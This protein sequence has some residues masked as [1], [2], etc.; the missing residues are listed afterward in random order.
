MAEHDVCETTLQ[1][2]VSLR[3]HLLAQYITAK[4][5]NN[6]AGKK[7]SCTV[8]GRRKPTKKRTIGNWLRPFYV[9]N[10]SL[11]N[12]YV[13]VS[14]R[15]YVCACACSLRAQN[16]F[17]WMCACVKDSSSKNII[18]NTLSVATHT[19]TAHV[20]WA[21]DDTI[22]MSER[23]VDSLALHQK[24]GNDAL[25]RSRSRNSSCGRSL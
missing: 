12:V 15:A 24:F 17:V 5:V 14:A 13:C 8:K 22:H 11:V 1:M 7:V 18:A 2:F 4:I 3:I 19:R 20:L 23:R 16:I 25:L 6:G 10:R 9:L 21:R